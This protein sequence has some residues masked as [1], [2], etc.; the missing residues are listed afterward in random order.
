MPPAPNRDATAPLLRR[1]LAAGAAWSL[2]AVAV[3]ASAPA[4][5]A[6]CAPTTSVPISTHSCTAT[7]DA[8]NEGCGVAPGYSGASSWQSNLSW[9]DGTKRTTFVA[10]SDSDSST[11]KVVTTTFDFP[12]LANVAYTITFYF[13]ANKGYRGS[14]TC[15]TNRA[16]LVITGPTGTLPGWSTQSTGPGSQ[17]LV[18]TDSCTVNGPRN[19]VGTR[20]TTSTTVEY[21]PTTLGTATF[22]LTVTEAAGAVGG[23]NDD[24][25][26]APVVKRC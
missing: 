6:S 4:M 11:P 17:Y 13:A 15:D 7:G 14:G 21:T 22:T 26:I 24:F 19:A 12:V 5:A 8:F 25:W 18:P 3:A 23:N 16:D 1:T 2:P 20:V 9:P 10:N